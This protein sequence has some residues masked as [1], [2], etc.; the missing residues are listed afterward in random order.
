MSEDFG[1]D[2]KTKEENLNRN[3]HCHRVS[4]SL[5]CL[6]AL[7]ASKYVW[8]SKQTSEMK[9]I[10]NM[11]RQSNNELLDAPKELIKGFEDMLDG[12]RNKYGPNLSLQN[13]LVHSVCLDRFIKER[14]KKERDRGEIQHFHS[15]EEERNKERKKF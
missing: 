15:L 6:L 2:G 14:N 9:E 10:E 4:L 3:P 11:E 12:P 13:R 5:P 8:G 1:V 7:G